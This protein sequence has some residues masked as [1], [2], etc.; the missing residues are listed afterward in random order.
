MAR[1]EAIARGRI[2]VLAEAAERAALAGRLDRAHRYAEL[3]REVGMRHNVPLPREV[4]P[5]LCRGCD[6]FLLPGATS[7]VRLRGG[8]VVSTCLRCGRRR[9][10]LA[11]E[12]P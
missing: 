5:F 10:V 8:R 11:G 6:G 9:R 12:G 7:R 2:R 1:S 3:I 4:K